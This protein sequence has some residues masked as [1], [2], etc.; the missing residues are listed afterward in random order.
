MFDG[1]GKGEL[2]GP[3]YIGH[4]AGT[5]CVVSILGGA[6]PAGGNE[7]AR[8]D[9]AIESALLLA[10]ILFPAHPAF[11]ACWARLLL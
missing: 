1:R 9:A 6:G 7:L 10:K 4:P 5:P 2:P 8:E 11:R 3:D